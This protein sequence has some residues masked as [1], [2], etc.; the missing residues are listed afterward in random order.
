MYRISVLA[1]PASNQAMPLTA[2][3][4]VSPRKVGITFRLQPRA[5]PGAVAD[6]VSR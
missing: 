3:R 6:L 2:P 5:L 4:L 1:Q